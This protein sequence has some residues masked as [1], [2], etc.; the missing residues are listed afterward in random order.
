MPFTEKDIELYRRDVRAAGREL[1]PAQRE[2]L[3]K[4][5]ERSAGK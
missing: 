2:G 3:R 5:K 4:F 1:T